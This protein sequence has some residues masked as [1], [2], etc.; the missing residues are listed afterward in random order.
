METKIGRRMTKLL[1][2][3]L[4]ICIFCSL[5]LQT[6][7]QADSTVLNLD[8]LYW[9]DIQFE[10]KRL[11]DVVISGSR[12]E[13]ERKDVTDK[14]YVITKQEIHDNGYYTLVDVMASL[15]GIRTSQPGSGQ[16]GETF[17][18]RGLQGNTYAKILINDIPFKAFIS[19]SIGISSQLPIRQ[20]ERIEVIY[21]TKA[22][23]YGVDASAG[24]INIILP[25]GKEL[26]NGTFDVDIG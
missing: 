3:L 25:Q 1:K 6:Y 14:V 7:A 17:Y 8:K 16:E 21:G 23:I 11:L 24:I 9:E 26:E 10:K 12:T 15:P 22:S 19:K 13:E 5:G 2:R 20:A 4:F 18:M